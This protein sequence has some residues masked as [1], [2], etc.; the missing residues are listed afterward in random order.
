MPRFLARA[1][2]GEHYAGMIRR[3]SL[4]FL[5]TFQFESLPASA[6]LMRAI[7]VLRLREANCTSA[8]PCRNPPRLGSLGT[9]GYLTRCPAE[10]LAGP[11][12]FQDGA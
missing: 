6:S 8:A 9:A 2:L 3:W 5:D 4:A 12:S 7:E 11:R 1:K 10:E